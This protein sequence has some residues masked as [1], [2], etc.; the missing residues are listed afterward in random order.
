MNQKHVTWKRVTVYVL[1]LF[2]LALGVSISIK[3]DLGVSPVSS[4]AYAIALT[5]GLSVGITTILANIL[6]IFIQVILHK[7]VDIRDFLLQLLIGFLFGFFIDATLFLVRFLPTHETL[8]TQFLYLTVS[9]FIVGGGLLGYLVSKLPL[10]PYDALTY[11][12]SERFKLEFSKAKITSDILNVCVAGAICIIFIG[13]FGAVGIG[14][15][16]AAYFIGKILGIYMKWFKMPLEKWIF[17]ELD[18]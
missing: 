10:M 5:F 7:K 1:G 6:F 3:A 2:F 11:V 9:L 15:I 14:T 12:I 18:E 8:I 13:S 17:N 4:L 16:I